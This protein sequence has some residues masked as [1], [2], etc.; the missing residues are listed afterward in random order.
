MFKPK[1]FELF[2][3]R[4]FETLGSEEVSELALAMGVNELDLKRHF[5]AGEIPLA[6]LVEFAERN[7]YSL[8][9]I[10]FG[11]KRGSYLNE[12]Q[13]K[14]GFPVPKW[15]QEKSSMTSQIKAMKCEISALE[16]HNKILSEALSERSATETGKSYLQET[17]AKYK[18]KD[19]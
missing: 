19:I 3:L 16:S 18:Q 13:A 8:D 2:K 17:C 1:N 15:E 12:P 4:L 11:R 9:W 6:W 10:L 7:E 5:E 14:Y